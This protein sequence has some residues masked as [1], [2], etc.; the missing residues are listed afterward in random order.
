M[1]K[2]YLPVFD[3][4]SSVVSNTVATGSD[5]AEEIVI[6]FVLSYPLMTG[7]LRCC[8][9]IYSCKLSG[10]FQEQRL[11]SLPYC[12][13]LSQNLSVQTDTNLKDRSQDRRC[14]IIEPGFFLR[15][16]SF[17]HFIR[18]LAY[19]AVTPALKEFPCSWIRT[20]AISVT[21]GGQV[22]NRTAE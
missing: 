2:V 21:D 16:R 1:P 17:V 15:E 20:C 19:D 22:S 18:T 12:K 4:G 8:H 14:T 5:L 11:D 6:C 3:H 13:V 9:M 10:S 7:T